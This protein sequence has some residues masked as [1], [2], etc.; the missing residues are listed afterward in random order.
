MLKFGDV[1]RQDNEEY[2]YLIGVR[3]YMYVAKI[4]SRDISCCLNKRRD[5]ELMRDGNLVNEKPDYAFVILQ[6]PEF[7][8]R[9]ARYS[10]P[11]M[12][13]D[14]NIQVIGKLIPEDIKEL[15]EEICTSDAISLELKERIQEMRA[16]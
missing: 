5:R 14:N 3:K 8:D 2:A 12:E 7:S 1:F 6:S 10:E 11:G 4:L 13:Y 9:A 15:L 16:K